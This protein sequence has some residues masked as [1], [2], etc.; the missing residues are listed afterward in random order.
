MNNAPMNSIRENKEVGGWWLV[1]S[2]KSKVELNKLSN[3]MNLTD[4]HIPCIVWRQH[5][6]P[7]L[8]KTMSISY[9]P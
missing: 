8:K 2:K 7:Y 9:A 3:F 6:A 5:L 4:Y 1:E